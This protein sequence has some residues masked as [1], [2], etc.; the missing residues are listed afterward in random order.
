MAIDRSVFYLRLCDVHSKHGS[1]GFQL[2]VIFQ[3]KE[4]PG[5]WLV[6][7]IADAYKQIEF[8]SPLE[9]NMQ[10]SVFF[11]ASSVGYTPPAMD[12][13]HNTVSN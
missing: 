6:S 10:D 13:T 4:P 8:R 12:L 3:N 5:I 7:R 2:N 9:L 11:E 1:K